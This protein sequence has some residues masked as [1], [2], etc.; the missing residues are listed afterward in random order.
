M[1]HQYACRSLSEFGMKFVN[2]FSGHVITYYYQNIFKIMFR[3]CG[4]DLH[5]FIADVDQAGSLLNWTTLNDPL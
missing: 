3:L 5:L 1:Q 4:L 2:Y